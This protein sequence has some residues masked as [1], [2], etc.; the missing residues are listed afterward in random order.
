[1]HFRCDHC[2]N[3]N[4]STALMI[5]CQHNPELAKYIFDSDKCTPNILSMKNKDGWTALMFACQSNF[6]LAKYIFDSDKCTHDILSIQ[7]EYG[8]TALMIACQC[9]TELAKY[10]LDSDKCIPDILS[11]RT[12]DGW[13]A[14]MI[15]CKYNP[16]LVKYIFDSDKF[17]PNILSMK[18]KD[19][20]TPLM[21]FCQ[22]CPSLV[23]SLMEKCSYEILAN[24]C[25]TFDVN[26]I[27]SENPIKEYA[28]NGGQTFLHVLAIFFPYT[29][30]GIKDMV[31][32]ELLN[33]LDN[34]GLTCSQY[35]LI[36]DLHL[37]ENKL[38]CPICYEIL[39]SIY[40]YNPCGHIIC[41]ECSKIFNY[42]IC[43][44]C[45]SNITNKVKLFA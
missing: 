40:V 26:A 16:E 18:S 22:Y 8:W 19:G 1:M 45:K 33:M 24:K 31:N 3:N 37:T 29:F 10:I 36:H 13:S 42:P 23:K 12:K 25:I 32:P 38:L 20:W 9:N 44:T 15:A 30:Y 5:A 41:D 11:I 34:S 4:G 27:K 28:K 6:E 43:H 2:K 7:D 21:M 14:L 17:T 39:N 35:L